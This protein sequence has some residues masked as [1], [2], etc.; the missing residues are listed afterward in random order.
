M[1]TIILLTLLICSNAWGALA[2]YYHSAKEISDLLEDP[3]LVST[4]GVSDF[5]KSVER[6]DSELVVKTQSCSV[7][8]KSTIEN[9]NNPEAPKFKFDIQKVKCE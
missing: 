7:V 8:V 4:L 6:K 1:K 9:I 2:P 3:Q 5:I